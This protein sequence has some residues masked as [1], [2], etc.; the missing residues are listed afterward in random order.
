MHM[1]R[2]E[3]YAVNMISYTTL[4]EAEFSSANTIVTGN[5][6]F[7][8]MCF[9]WL[10]YVFYRVSQKKCFPTKLLQLIPSYIVIV[11]T[12]S[13]KKNLPTKANFHLV[14]T[15]S[16]QLF[17]ATATIW[18]PITARWWRVRDNKKK[19]IF[20]KLPARVNNVY[21]LFI[22]AHTYVTRLL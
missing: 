13:A 12:R 10:K 8:S 14:S 19:N 9:S 21:L 6:I 7:L 4:K 2:Y 11:F 1:Y 18:R 3:H 5:Q 15:K 16:S 17:L 22:V 20:M